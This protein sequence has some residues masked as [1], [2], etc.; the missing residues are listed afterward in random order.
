VRLRTP[1]GRGGRLWLLRRLAVA[2]RGHDVLEQKRQALLRQLDRLEE[3]LDD[4]RRAWQE[5]ACEAELWWQRAAV[6]AGERPL[7]LA[8]SAVPGRAEVNLVWRNALGV[9]YPSEA[10][11][12]VPRGELFPTGG[13]AALPYA[14][15]A[16]TRALEA[17][18]Q[19][20]AA[21]LARERTARELHATTLRLRALERRWI[22]EHER[23]LHE[24]EL[25][26]DESEREE[27]ARV[28]WVIGRLNEPGRPSSRRGLDDG[29]DGPGQRG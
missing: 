29:K 28:R 27:S 13:S 12:A 3:L 2:R 14:A 18:A 10:T 23:A 25:A 17:G 6:L 7:E 15:Q 22:P 1:P 8:S 16:H 21:E 26:L 4:A 5:S 20:G 24:V 11:V 19:L 9:V